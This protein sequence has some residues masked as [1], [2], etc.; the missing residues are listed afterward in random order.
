MK[1]VTSVDTQ[2]KTVT[3]DQKEKYAYDT[4]VLATGAAPRRLPVDGADL[5]NVFTLRHVEDAQKIDAGVYC[6]PVLCLAE[7]L[8]SEFV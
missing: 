4:L 7:R 3:I 1:V 6:N 2:S 5:D 8:N